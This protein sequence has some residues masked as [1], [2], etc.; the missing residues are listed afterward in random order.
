MWPGTLRDQKCQPVWP[1]R[2][3]ES[4]G[5]KK[6]GQELALIPQARLAPREG[7]LAPGT[8]CVLLQMWPGGWGLGRAGASRPWLPGCYCLVSSRLVYRAQLVCAGAGRL[9]GPWVMALL[10][11]CRVGF[12]GGLLFVTVGCCEAARGPFGASA[13]P[14]WVETA[15]THPGLGVSQV[16]PYRRGGGESGWPS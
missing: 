7:A 9:A 12:P 5:T 8:G 4:R 3:S 13:V 15:V 2:C 16:G 10:V 6:W 1:R 11:E 14:G